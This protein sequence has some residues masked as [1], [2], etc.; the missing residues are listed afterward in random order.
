MKTGPRGAGAAGV[1]VGVLL[2]GPAAWVA[3]GWR[4]DAAL[5]RADAARAVERDEQAQAAM[6]AVEAARS[7]G[8]RRVAAMERTR[9][10]AQ[11]QAASAVA[12]AAD[13]RAEYD[14]MR[15]HANAL[16]RASVARDPSLAGGGPTGAAPVDLLAYML[17]R[18]VDRAAALAEIADR[19]RIAGLTCEQV[20]DALR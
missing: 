9:D 17:G 8:A 3:Q 7:E 12:D 15:N 13:A 14:R 4:G 19:A 2:A 16:A 11:K 6:A 10:D 20:Y 1:L 18:A 5:A